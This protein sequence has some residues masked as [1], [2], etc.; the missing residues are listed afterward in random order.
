MSE[1]LNKLINK[2][3]RSLEAARRL[4]T[5]GDFDFSV[6][7]A[8]YAMFY[9]AESLLLTQEMSFSKHSTIIAAFGKHFAKTGLLPSILHSH[10][11]DAF[12]DRQIGDY[13][14]IREITRLKAK[15]H[16]ENAKE[17]MKHTIKYLNEKGYE[18]GFSIL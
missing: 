3:Q 5:E 8:Y 18:V 15:T 13:E 12:K 10:L 9:C 11:L 16:L 7:R 2:A 14:V 1:E 6:S 17:F 4:Y